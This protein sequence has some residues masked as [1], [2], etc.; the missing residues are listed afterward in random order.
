MQCD[1]TYK[2][3]KLFNIFYRFI[4]SKEI[5]LY[6][7]AFGPAVEAR[8]RELPP[9]DDLRVNGS[10]MFG[11]S[12]PCIADA[13]SL[14]QNYKFIGGYHI[15]EKDMEPLPNVIITFCHTETVLLCK[16]I[17]LKIYSFLLMKK[18]GTTGCV[19]HTTRVFG[20]QFE[21]FLCIKKAE[22]H[23]KCN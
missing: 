10:M 11:N 12:H 18:T 13:I 16:S 17:V 9:Y 20:L 6:Y 19:C 3:L 15:I 1:I 23:N 22:N 14:P 4:S 2:I 7:E 8:G 21:I 5:Q